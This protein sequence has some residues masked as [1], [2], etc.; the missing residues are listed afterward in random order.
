MRR[1]RRRGFTLTELMIAVA[2][3]GVL[4]ALG[5]FGLRHHLRSAMAAEATGSVGAICRGAVAAYEREDASGAAPKE[6][7]S[8]S[9]PEHVLCPSA[10]RVP[11]SID[12]VKGRKYQA[13]SAPGEDFETE[14]WACVRFVMRRPMAY[15]YQYVA[16]PDGLG[17]EASAR[18]DLDGD[19]IASRYARRGAVHPVTR[20]LRVETEIAS[21]DPLE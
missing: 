15:Q 4:A 17:F 19:G 1:G 16:S 9:A 12:A 6:G 7:A 21:T 11:S 5:V 14:A 20:M 3:V 13:S 18:G 2:L 8:D 10:E